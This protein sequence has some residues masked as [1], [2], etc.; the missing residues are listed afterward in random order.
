M[1]KKSIFVALFNDTGSYPH[2]GCRAVSDAHDSQLQHLNIIVLYR[3]FVTEYEHL[4]AGDIHTSRDRFFTSALVTEISNVD[5]ILINGEGTI[6][7]EFG[8]HLLAIIA[9]A[10]ELGK[11]TY[12]INS[13]LQSIPERYFGTLRK[14]K[15]LTVRDLCSYEYLK[16]NNIPCRLVPDSI[17][18]AEFNAG[19]DSIYDGKIIITDCIE[20][21][22]DIQQQIKYLLEHY[23]ADA[24]YF[25][26]EGINSDNWRDSLKKFSGARLIVT[27]RHHGVYLALMAKKPFIALSSNTWKIEGLLAA[28]GGQE[29]LWK[30]NINLVSLCEKACASNK[31][32]FKIFSNRFLKKEKTAFDSIA[33]HFSLPWNEDFL[34]KSR[35]RDEQLDRY[36]WACKYI[37]SGDRVFDAACGLGYGGHVIRHL[38]HA[39]KVVGIDGSDYAID[40]A[41]KA[42]PC[43]EGR[44]EY[45]VGMLPDVLS[46]YPDGS[47]DVIIS[48]ET[49]EHVENPQVLLGEFYRLLTP[50]GR[51]IVSV[52]NDWS[53]ETGVDPNPY[54]LYV[55]DWAKLKRELGAN[56]ILEEAFAQTASQCKVASQKNM[57]ERRPR[58]LNQVQI[59]GNSPADCEWW[60]MTAMKSPLENS[61]PYKERV[62]ANIAES[63]HP[64]TRYSSSYLNPWLMHSLVNVGHRLRNNSA[65]ENL[66][67]KVMA[68][69]PKYSND[70][71]A[72]LCVY[73]Y[74]VLNRSIQDATAVEDV[75]S[76][77]EAV[78]LNPE[79]DPMGFRWRVS[80]LFVKAKLLQ[81]LG[82]LDRAKVAFVDCADHDVRS[83]GIHLATKTTEAWFLAGKIAHALG[84]SKE[85]QSYW[86]RGIEVG[87]I[88]L[89]MSLDDILINRSFPNRFNHGDG[90][91]EYIV[92]WDNIARCANGLNLLRQGGPIDAAALDDCFQTEY[93][94]VTRDVINARADLNSITQ[95][96]VNTRQLLV[97]RTARLEQCSLELL[98]RTRDLVETREL[99]IERTERLERAVA[100]TSGSTEQRVDR[101]KNT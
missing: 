44:A 63:G 79:K 52:P 19:T 55:Y 25:P 57:W 94:T 26:L 38:T 71:L 40:Y 97:E 14:L 90:V 21:R 75:I 54:H 34:I 99:L 36:K 1:N 15:D 61:Q 18:F 8:L 32:F 16:S 37:K 3:H 17:L 11:P 74:C 69:S 76:K 20:N 50:G 100:F 65:L 39:A 23:E 64:S 24:V 9:G 62:F 12:L 68:I 4:Y 6:H 80:L 7:H 98:H 31:E 60:L 96:L 89:S 43:V 48:F 29:W 93:S 95:E 84:D 77:I 10:Q 56:F 2:V 70:S 46:E 33:R 83:F 73:A 53:D 67:S 86:E 91:R 88:L 87:S 35:I 66:A 5:A 58:S 78:R 49:L 82:Q 92:S 81:A 47:F 28:I 42:F 22:E 30:K 45:R 51:V 59:T 85:A 13:V 27:G 101:A 41:R 72:A